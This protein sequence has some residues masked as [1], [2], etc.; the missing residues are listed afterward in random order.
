[1]RWGGG[2]PP[3]PTL[4]LFSLITSL[5]WTPTLVTICQYQWLQI[6]RLTIPL[7]W[8]ILTENMAR[9][10]LKA[11]RFHRAVQA[12]FAERFEGPT[13]AQAKGWPPIG[14]GE[15]TL[16]LA[17]TGSGKTLAA[18][19]ACINHLL[20]G[21]LKGDIPPGVHTLYIS[22]LKALNYDIERNL[23]EP[24]AGIKHKAKEMGLN[25]P[26]IRVGVRTGDTSP[27]ERQRML[28]NPPHILITTPESLHLILTSTK[29]RAILRTLHCLIVD[30]IHSLSPN[31]RGTFLAIL[32]ERLE[33]LTKNP[34]QRIGLSAT[35]RPLEEV[36][37]F[38]GGGKWMGGEVYLPRSV[39]L[40]DCGMRKQLDLKVIS[41]VEDMK[42]LPD[43][44]VWPSIYRRLLQLILSHRSTLIFAN[45]RRAVERITKGINDLAGY[46]LA[47]AHHGSVSKPIRRQIEAQLKEGKLPA[48]VATASL[49]LG[50]DMGAID[51]V[52]QVES[53]KS[54]ARGLQRVGRAGHLYKQASKG[55]FIP[56]TR[57]DLLEI[58]AITRA[59]RYGLVA[60]LRIPHHPLDILA[61]QIVAMVAMED[62]KVD[63]LFR[64]VRQAYPYQDLPYP[65]FLQVLEMLSGRFALGAF[66][67]LKPRISWDRANEMLYPLPGSQRVAIVNGGAI[68]ETGQFGCYLPDGTKL[69]ELDE[70]FVYE[71]RI[72]D[73]F[74]LGTNTWRVREIGMDRVVVEPA[75]D[76]LAQMPFWHGE[77]FSRGFELG[78]YLGALLRELEARI[79]HPSVEEWLRVECCLDAN[80]ASNL[81]EYLLDQRERGGTIPNDRTILIEGFR[82]ELGNLRL[83]ILSPYGGRVHLAWR[84]ALLALF[85][86]RWGIEPDSLHS[87]WGIL[88]QLSSDDIGPAT[89]L[90]LSLSSD[91][92]EGLVTEELANSPLFGLRFRQN[93]ARALLLPKFK[94]GRRTPLWLQRL[95]AKDLLEICRGYDSFP[96][97]VETYREC[98]QD[99]LGLKELKEI[100]S[101]MRAGAIKVTVRDGTTPSPFSSSL[102]FDFTAKYIYEWDRPKPGA[103]PQL[104]HELLESLLQPHNP[105]FATEAIVELED[106]LQGKAKGYRARTEVELAEL[107]RRMGDLTEA[108]LVQR[109]V[110]NLSDFL[111]RL[112]HQGRIIQVSIP[113]VREPRRWILTEDFPLYRD[114]FGARV[115][116][117]Q[118][119]NLNLV[120]GE[121]PPAVAQRMILDRILRSHAFIDLEWLLDRYPFER[122]CLSEILQERERDGHLLKFSW[123]DQVKWAPPDRVEQVRRL[124][125]VHS[126]REVKPS[127]VHRYVDFLLKWQHRHPHARLSGKEGLI[128]LLGQLGGLPLPAEIWEKEVFAQRVKGYQSSWLDE[129]SSQGVLAWWG[130]PGGAGEWGRVCFAL[131]EDFP[132][133]RGAVGCAR[134]KPQDEVAE[135][136]IGVLS[137]R[138]ATF[139]T[140]LSLES[141]F[142][143]S[144]LRR[145]LWELIWQGEVTNDSF[146]VVRGGRPSIRPLRQGYGRRGRYRP[147][148]GRWIL[149][150]KPTFPPDLELLARQLLKRYGVV[151]RELYEL[152]GWVIPWRELYQIFS[153]LEWRGEVHRGYFVRGFSGAQ[154]ALPRAAAELKGDNSEDNPPL[155][156][157]SCDPANL[158]GAASP[159]PLL[160][161]ANPRQ[162]FLRTPSNYL[163]LQ[164]GFPLLTIEGSKLTSWQELTTDQK[165]EVLGLL[166]QLLEDA[167][168]LKRLRSLKVEYWNGQ[169]VRRS[170]I[171]PLL[172]ELGFR[173]EY[174][175]MVLYRR[176]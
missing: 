7:V 152:E 81:R 171:F 162:K 5:P 86:R 36:A 115:R 161:P 94:P 111:D 42:N 131:R 63:E 91:R 140:D 53:P 16:I 25:L 150:P 32:L 33:R 148:G 127:P 64:F 172:K 37:K 134:A 109:V 45:N 129:L 141:G 62:W 126:H 75:P 120:G 68:P 74:V 10:G 164:D 110:G 67:D 157:N 39:K 65:L 69:G 103:N 28:R 106:R 80:A 70:E 119:Q 158:Y 97:V 93:A 108:E 27:A 1:M 40:V 163:I 112:R 47:R 154:F 142:P 56:K 95:K 8:P 128:S 155:L 55:R 30:E 125:L 15:N 169:P 12:W 38:L 71:A 17:P 34:L 85:R 84:L 105:L 166:P 31:K 138:G 23:Q 117:N 13:P 118:P 14:R 46:E 116:G 113:R 151:F 136:L 133:F 43:D 29:A 170:E 144:T 173:D 79:D 2:I 124:T 21:L 24:L 160:H 51:L 167:G 58:A 99:Q 76:R 59:M 54:V 66:K 96:I 156:I 102:L 50:I 165:R 49:E 22:P 48:L 149:L 146:V 130:S 57:A 19:L 44:S 89:D 159:L 100:L 41:P 3:L 35:Q 88:F 61:Q 135:S 145:A 78:A 20:E 83:A 123:G 90:I 73:L 72:G 176:F 18:F 122:D 121:F 52:C 147:F 101:Q 174:K 82:D 107:L 168:G 77:F 92:V 153:R 87:D 143:P 6:L 104:A 26:E 9:K 139:L 4:S 11:Y 132:H 175:A 114:G 60:P 98:L 137:K